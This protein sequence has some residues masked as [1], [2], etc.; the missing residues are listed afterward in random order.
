MQGLSEDLTRL[1]VAWSQGDPEALSTLIPMVCDDLR[2][3]ARRFMSG[4]S[5][6][7]ELQPTALVNEFFLKVG[8]DCNV[9]WKNRGHFFAFAAQTMRSIL[10]DQARSQKR[11]KRGGGEPVLKLGEGLDQVAGEDPPAHVDILAL[12]QALS[13]LEAKDPQAASVVKLRYFVGMTVA[14]T[15]AALDISPATV[16]REWRFA[17]LWLFRE[18][19]E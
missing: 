5:D 16:K 12:H 17:Q 10:V 3:T 13:R 19:N 7:H 11:Q 14:E 6:R 18:L 1:L 2:M 9:P 15:A 4:D 8:M